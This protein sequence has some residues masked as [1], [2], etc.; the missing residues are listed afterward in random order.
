MKFSENRRLAFTVL[1]VV[2]LFSIV[3]QGSIAMQNKRGDIEV[4]F[5]E[6]EM[7]D[8]MNR[9]ADK[10]ILIAQTAGLYLTEGVLEQYCAEATAQALRDGGYL[11]A[12]QQLESLS[13]QLKEAPDPNACLAALTELTAAVEKTYSGVEMLTLSNEQLRDIKLAYYN[14][15]GGIDLISRDG[16]NDRSYTAKAVNFNQDLVGFPASWFARVLKVEPLSTY[17]G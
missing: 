16:E 9:C 15:T 3:I 13:E 5:M 10:S 12:A 2:I 6:G 14:Y 1:A 17:G 8:L 11:D 4:L 7:H